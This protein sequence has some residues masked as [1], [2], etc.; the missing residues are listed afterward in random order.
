MPNTLTT[1]DPL[2]PGATGETITPWVRAQLART[3]PSPADRLALR[4]L[5]WELAGQPV[6]EWLLAPD[7]LACQRIEAEIHQWAVRLGLYRLDSTKALT[8][9]PC[10]I[11][12]SVVLPGAPAELVRLTSMYWTLII[13]FD[14]QVVETGR[15]PQPYRDTI[16]DILL[17]GNP[18]VDPDPFH[19]AFAE[20]RA[21]IV[22]LGGEALL[23]AFADLVAGAIDT[24]VREWQHRQ[25]DRMP[26][27]DQYLRDA[28]TNSH[29]LPGMLLQRLVPGLIPP[30][31]RWPTEL[32][33]AAQLVTVLARLENDLLSYRKDEHDGAVNACWILAEEYGIKPIQSVP[34]VLG[35]INALR[36]QLDDL[37][38]AIRSDAGSA[39]LA[40]QADAVHDWVDACYAW[41]LTV[42]R[43]GVSARKAG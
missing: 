5:R 24:Y 35:M 25:H 41:F 26:A 37:I 15:S 32:T 4:P 6:R 36:V 42:A 13:A 21:G 14:D 33:H 9:G 39:E 11:L 40:R 17:H 22:E 19:L 29:I 2:A 7:P 28:V 1:I 18:P 31:A 10:T 3:H 30:D 20:V 23:P 38:A 16:T 43:Y 27:M 8:E 12:A 34:S